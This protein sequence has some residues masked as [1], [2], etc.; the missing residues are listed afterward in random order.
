MPS[1]IRPF[2]STGR[3]LVMAH[4]GGAGLWPENT[5]Y[6]F[7]QA[8]EIGA[9][10]LETDIRAT[11]DGHLVVIHD[12]NLDRTT[13]GTGPVSGMTLHQLKQLDASVSRGEKHP[14][15]ICRRRPSG[16]R[17]TVPTLEEVFLR[18]PDIRIN[19]D[20]KQL[21]PPIVAPFCRMIRKHGMARKVLAASFDHRTIASFRRCCPEVAT[22]A[23]KPE[24]QWFFLLHRI[25][26]SRFSRLPGRSFQI[27]VQIPVS[28]GRFRIASRRFVRHAHRIG[29]GVHVWTVNEMSEM[30]R[31]I[32]IGV[33]GIFTDYPDRLTELLEKPSR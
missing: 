30:R 21:D 19:I 20:I 27:P 24:I 13:S 5:I 18:F 8:L 23:S 17:I 26:L 2:L 28:F 9:D 4:R 12:P 31:M 6:A 1:D 10:M 14:E 33:D 25:G 15:E 7:H 3:P 22:A 16:R 32:D 29:C 11:A